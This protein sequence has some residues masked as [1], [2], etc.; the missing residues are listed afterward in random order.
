M[1]LM[2]GLVLASVSVA[3]LFSPL[4]A[5]Q[6]VEQKIAFHL[7]AQDLNAALLSFA[8][9]AD[10]QLVYDVSLVQG[11]RSSAIDGTLTPEEGLSRLLAGS[12]LTYRFTGVHSVALERLPADATTLAPVTVEGAQSRAEESAFGPVAGYVAKHSATATKTDTPILETPRSVSVVTNEELEQRQPTSLSEALGYVAGVS[13]ASRGG[14]DRYDWFSIRGFDASTSLFRDGLQAQGGDSKIEPYALERI[15]VLK[16]PASILYGQVSPG[17]MINAVTK[18]P[19]QDN[20]GEVET[21]VGTDNHTEGRADVSAS[22]ND[23]KTLAA[24]MVLLKKNSDTSVKYSKDDRDYAMLSLAWTPDDGTSLT[25]MGDYRHD[26]TV[27]PPALPAEGTAYAG[28]FGTVSRDLFVGAVGSEELKRDQYSIGYNLDHSFNDHVSF[29]QNARIS[30]ADSPDFFGVRAG[31]LNADGRTVSRYTFAGKVY[32]NTDEVDNQLHLK[33]DTGPVNHHLIA[34][35]DYSQD[36]YVFNYGIGTASDLDIYNPDYGGTY[37]KPAIDSGSTTLTKQT[38]VYLQDQA[39][40]GDHWTLTLGARH[41]NATVKAIDYSDGSFS[42]Q[43]DHATT[44]NTGLVYL[45]DSGLAPYVSYATSFLPNTG[46]DSSGKAFHAT[47]A[48]QGEMGVKFQSPGS[49]SMT[50]LSAFD[51]VEDHVLTADP[52]DSNFQVDGGQ[53]ESKG[54]EVESRLGLGYGF[55]LI[56]TATMMDVRIIKSNDGNEGHHPAGVPNHMASVWLDYE[57]K[58]GQLQGLGM[59]AGV[60]YVGERPV[61]SSSSRTA[62]AYAVTD[63]GIR[64]QLDSLGLGL[65]ASNLFDTAYVQCRDASDCAWGQGRSVI[66]SVKYRW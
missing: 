48:Q 64:Y 50:T 18:R 7:P 37:V 45:F 59:G 1:A 2:M 65:T 38:G 16:G 20:F 46:T 19:S 42:R 26:E 13:A 11:R 27:F 66:G 49:G 29:T 5:A 24:R 57:V 52:N 23:D 3:A 47:T 36:R 21:L 33:G 60:R 62:D 15:E 58:T 9:E 61:D 41:D 25:V 14:D 6:A 55:R 17:G 39:K 34:G 53:W 4:Q 32:R 22:L 56:S 28:R 51:L 54:V 10:L 31:S 40:M 44:W 35:V 43:D 8:R 30:I 63:L 12:G